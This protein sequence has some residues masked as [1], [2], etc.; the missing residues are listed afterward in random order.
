MSVEGQRVA[1]SENIMAYGAQELASSKNRPLR[2]AWE[3]VDLLPTLRA[4]DLIQ[5][6]SLLATE[7]QVDL[8]VKRVNYRASFIKRTGHAYGCVIHQVLANRKIL[9]TWQPNI[10][11]MLSWANTTATKAKRKKQSLMK[12][13]THLSIR[14]C[15]VWTAPH[16]T[17][18]SRAARTRYRVL[19]GPCANSTPAARFLPSV[20]SRS[21]S[22]RVMCAPV[23]TVRFG[24]ARTSEVR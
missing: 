18:T 13:R 22:T 9:E 20:R 21:R 5:A 11:K 4:R 16:D 15:G 2:E 6:H 14:I 17:T 12:T 19:N 1:Q 3:R 24:R 8:V 7:A 10:T 23:R